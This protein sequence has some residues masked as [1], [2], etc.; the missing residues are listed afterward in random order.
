MFAVNMM[1]TH[2]KQKLDTLFTLDNTFF[3]MAKRGRRIPPL[4]M[5]IPVFMLVIF[6]GAGFSEFVILE[7]LLKNK[8]SP[9]FKKYYYFTVSFSCITLLLWL[10]I[11]YY[12]K[13]P[14]LSIGLTKRN[15]LKNY[16]GMHF[17][18]VLLFFLLYI[19]WLNLFTMSNI[20]NYF[21]QWNWIYLH[22][23]LK[24]PIEQLTSM[25]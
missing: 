8:L 13:R 15:A 19:V 16:M 9:F 11:R 25:C 20:F 4:A 5:A 18:T 7:L 1:I 6:V 12:E 3:K 17:I 14:F 23:I 24:K 21:V 2:A 10:W 22:S